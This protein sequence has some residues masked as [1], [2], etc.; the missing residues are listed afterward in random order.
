MSDDW[1]SNV[2]SFNAACRWCDNGVVYWF[3]LYVHYLNS[4]NR[5]YNF[6]YYG[7]MVTRLITSLFL[8]PC[9]RA[10]PWGWPEC[11]PKHVGGHFVNKIYHK[12]KVPLLVAYIFW[13]WLLYGWNTLK[14]HICPAA[15]SAYAYAYVSTAAKGRGAQNLCARPWSWGWVQTSRL[16]GGRPGGRAHTTPLG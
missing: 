3:Q 10:S 1:C 2:V 13:T 5:N 9:I 8:Y 12:I 4:V 6:N 15:A 11:R 7:V 14:L 16:G